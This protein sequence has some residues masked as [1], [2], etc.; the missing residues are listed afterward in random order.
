MVFCSRRG[1]TTLKSQEPLDFN[2][3]A[4]GPVTEGAAAGFNVVSGG[5]LPT[6]RSPLLGEAICPDGWSCC[7]K[8]SCMSEGVS[9]RWEWSTAANRSVATISLWRSLGIYG[10]HVQRNNASALQPVLQHNTT[11]LQDISNGRPCR[12]DEKA[13]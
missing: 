5:A 9:E 3:V 8:V 13:R 1:V 2:F 4:E 11:H 12:C 6:K 7:M 10:R